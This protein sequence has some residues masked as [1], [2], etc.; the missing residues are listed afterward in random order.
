M[1]DV[2]PIYAGMECV[3]YA[4]YLTLRLL[5]IAAVWPKEGAGRFVPISIRTPSIADCP[6][7]VTCKDNVR[8]QSPLDDFQENT[9]DLND[10]QDI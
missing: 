8:H 6:G 10:A 5:R 9:S 2:A 3:Q 7:Q 1:S 4:G